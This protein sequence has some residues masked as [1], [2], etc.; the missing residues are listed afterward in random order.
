VLFAEQVLGV[1]LWQFQSDL[2]LAIRDHRHV[3]VA[4]GR[5]IGKDFALACA[6]LWWY[7]SFKRAR[8]FLLAPS[9]EQL[10]GVLYLEIRQLFEGSGRCLKCKAAD[11]DG[12]RP[13]PHSAILTGDVGTQARTGI[14]GAGFRR[15]YGKTAMRGGMMRGFSGAK[16]LGIEDEASD[17]ED[18]IDQ[19]LVGNLAASDCH[20]VALSNPTKPYGFFYRAFHEERNLFHA[21]QRSSEDNPNVTEGREVFPGLASTEWLKEREM[22]WGRGSALWASDVEGRFPKAQQ[23]QLF[24][25]DVIKLASSEDRRA[26]A[27]AFGRLYVGIDVAGDGEDGDETVFAV[28]RGNAVLELLAL[29]GLTRDATL[30]LLLELLLKHSEPTDIGED[31]PVVVLDRDGHIG[32][33][34][35]DTVNAY[36][37]RNEENEKRFRLIGFQG[38]LPPKSKMGQ[39]YRLN[40]DLLFAGL[41][42]WIKLGGY[43]PPDLKLQGE[44]TALRW[45]E[46]EGGK[47][48]LEPKRDLKVRLGRSPDRAD[49]FAL[50]TWTPAG[51]HRPATATEPEP[52]PPRS[53]AASDQ[54]SPVLDPYAGIDTWRER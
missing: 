11:P 47:S 28:R 48:Q 23:G 53:S 25:L 3:A 15:I 50:S 4:G 12:P 19:A 34:R 27:E 52:T 33:Q 18:E 31:C 32:A 37:R 45:R 7:A 9:Y 46:V 21:I 41:V 39:T 30:G 44:L 1:S 43:V 14:K 29:R 5:K 35:F 51:W 22:A 6:A 42:E 8:V 40:R 10:D 49:A 54:Q 38:S 24:S 13:C 20:R 17:I 2:L 36:R 26:K 16:V